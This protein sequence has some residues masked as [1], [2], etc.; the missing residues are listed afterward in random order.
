MKIKALLSLIKG[1][2]ARGGVVRYT[3]IHKG[4]DMA[5]A[6][7]IADYIIRSI[8]VDPL[9]LQ[10]LLYYTQAVSL[11][12]YDKLAFNDPIEA[13]DY[14]PVVK[15]IYNVYKKFGFSSIPKT[16]SEL[17][18]LDENTINCADLVLEY[19]G[20]KS[21]PYLINET[22]SEA[23]WRDAYAR[24]QNTRIDPEAMKAYYKTIFTF[25]K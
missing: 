25:N 3:T 7:D 23:P 21:G 6:L 1:R 22:H 13:W 4:E 12:K 2:L 24:G 19:Y 10:K 5:K 15:S 16:E 8:E 9:K 20:T 18:D 17:S 11:V 14:G